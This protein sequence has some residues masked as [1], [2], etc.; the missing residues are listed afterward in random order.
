MR[1]KISAIN[2][3]INAMEET[4]RF[5][6]PFL[7]FLLGGFI[8]IAVSLV[9]L[10]NYLIFSFIV[11]WTGLEGNY[12]GMN[13]VIFTIFIITLILIFVYLTAFFFIKGKLLDINLFILGF[14]LI[15]FLDVLKI[16][17]IGSNFLGDKYT[18]WFVL[19]WAL[20]FYIDAFILKKKFKE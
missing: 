9:T 8:N 20:L 18:W 3:R 2:V 4:M 7:Y 19:I 14:L 13:I 5:L 16:V 12:Y 17:K 10:I 15:G 6:K 1:I 11:F